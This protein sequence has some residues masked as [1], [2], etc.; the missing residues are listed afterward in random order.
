M[1]LNRLLLNLSLTSA[2]LLLGKPVGL[3]FLSLSISSFLVILFRRGG[4]EER[5]GV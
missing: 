2:K 3:L 1:R 5:G 4:F